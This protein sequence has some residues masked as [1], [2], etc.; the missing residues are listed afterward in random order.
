M[1]ISKF[2]HEGYYDLTTYRAFKNIE[3][4]EK[5]KARFRPIVYIC[6]PY[7]GSNKEKNIANAQRYCRFA[8]DS[9]FLPIAPHLY[10]PQF[11]DDGDSRDHNTATF[12]N[13]VLM[14]KCTEVWVFGDTI[15]NG[16]ATEIRRA[17]ATQKPVRYFSTNCKEVR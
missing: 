7:A 5:R 1:R 4:D 10:F 11:M 3:K 2:N 6:S 13:T 17:E 12:M 14:T 9:G 15:S 16:M 8:V